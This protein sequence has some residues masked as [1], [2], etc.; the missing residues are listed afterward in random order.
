MNKSL[1]PRVISVTPDVDFKLHLTFNNGERRVFDAT[2]L[3][4]FGVF[5][6]LK[7][8]QFFNSVRVEHGSIAWP[9]NIDYCPDTLYA[10]SEP[11][12]LPCP[13]P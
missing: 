11:G 9:N 4:S 2:P 5:S 1:P 13:S 12:G 3:L 10:E 7:N 6:P 8:K